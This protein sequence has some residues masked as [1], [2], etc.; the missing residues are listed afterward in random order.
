M[1]EVLQITPLEVS[2][3]KLPYKFE[4][5]NDTRMTNLKKE[6]YCYVI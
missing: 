5:S 3:S 1:T 6:V 2:S 4:D